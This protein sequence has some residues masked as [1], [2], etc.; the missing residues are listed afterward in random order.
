VD[1][2]R[3][4]SLDGE[5]LGMPVGQPTEEVTNP[6]GK[7]HRYMRKGDNGAC[8]LLDS[9]QGL[10]RIHARLGAEHKPLACQG[11]P[12]RMIYVPGSV[13]LSLRSGCRYRHETFES[14][15]DVLE[16]ASWLS[17]LRALGLERCSPFPSWVLYLPHL[18]GVD[19]APGLPI[20]FAT[21]RRL[22]NK[23]ID[24][25]GAAPVE[26]ALAAVLRGLLQTVRGCDL[27]A[28]DREHAREDAWRCMRRFCAVLHEAGAHIIDDGTMAA[29]KALAD[30][31]SPATALP[32]LPQETQGLARELLVHEIWS[33]EPLFQAK[34]LL[35]SLVLLALNLTLAK[36]LAEIEKPGEPVSPA[37]FNDVFARTN[38][39][40]GAFKLGGPGA[41]IPF[42]AAPDAVLV[43]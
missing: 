31:S 34:S 38:A 18:A 42:A 25:L 20:S 28:L 29:A 35:P 24:D 1:L 14:G 5:R 16:G 12:A 30:E 10:C 43:G 17:E 3:L 19:L 2:E 26:E 36:A 6:D 13:R 39:L 8:T 37:R 22:E 7:T 41:L 23:V 40:V 33:L 21:Y 9:D 4:A 15:P 32:R 11:Y 27:P